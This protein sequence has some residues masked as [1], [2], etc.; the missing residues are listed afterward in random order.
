MQSDMLG[1]DK[2][3]YYAATNPH[4]S[5]FTVTRLRPLK[6]VEVT[7]PPVAEFS[8][9]PGYSWA[10]AR[11]RGCEQHLGWGFVP[12]GESPDANISM[13]ELLA[14]IGLPEYLPRLEAL[15]LTPS[16]LQ[17]L[18]PLALMRSP[19][20]ISVPEHRERIL[21][22]ACPPVPPRVEG[23]ARRGQYVFLAIINSK[24]SANLMSQRQLDRRQTDYEANTA[25]VSYKTLLDRR[26]ELLPFLLAQLGGRGIKESSSIP[27]DLCH[28]VVS[29]VLGPF[30]F[31]HFP[32]ER[33]A[34]VLRMLSSASK[35][36]RDTADHQPPPPVRSPVRRH[37]PHSP[38]PA[39][40]DEGMVE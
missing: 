11:C 12:D 30:R 1:L 27:P 4:G 6:A 7:G 5:R 8:W 35:R 19:I 39:E 32:S 22:A 26:D 33:H 3:W 29:M 28:S 17:H 9:F 24:L 40:E 15:G 34:R 21:A 38:E 31:A 16:D 25:P 2:V 13:A 20:G 23:A 36:K 37:D 14:R 18:S 10:M